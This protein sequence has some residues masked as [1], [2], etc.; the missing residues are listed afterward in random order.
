M[1]K[2]LGFEI[3]GSSTSKEMFLLYRLEK[4]FSTDQKSDISDLPVCK[5]APATESLHLKR[6]VMEIIY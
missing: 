5:R 4:W 1:E 6:Q 2:E 3:S